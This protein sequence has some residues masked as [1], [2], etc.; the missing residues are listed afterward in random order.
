MNAP[1]IDF[2]QGNPLRMVRKCVVAPRRFVIRLIN[3][4]TAS[5]V[6]KMTCRDAK[7]H[8]SAFLKVHGVEGQF[9]HVSIMRNE[10]SKKCLANGSFDISY[11]D[12]AGKSLCSSVVHVYEEPKIHIVNCDVKIS[13]AA[14]F[15]LS[16]YDEAR[17]QLH[18][19][20]LLW[21]LQ[22]HASNPKASDEEVR[23]AAALLAS[24]D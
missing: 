24:Y 11:Q 9:V 23:E 16:E 12:N 13:L 21:Y 8:A 1:R 14:H 2:M 15:A 19:Q 4:T 10:H 5:V 6:L 7:K 22:Y 17:E 3:P 18:K 20:T